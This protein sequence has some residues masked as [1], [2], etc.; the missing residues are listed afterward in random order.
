M[1][2]SSIRGSGRRPPPPREPSPTFVDTTLPL[3]ERVKCLRVRLTHG[4][5]PHQSRPLAP[6]SFVGFGRVSGAPDDGGECVVLDL[7]T[8]KRVPAAFVI[9]V[10]PVMKAVRTAATIARK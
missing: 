2:H 10:Q 8:S 1:V 6:G 3:H 9:A 5:V 4:N 7:D